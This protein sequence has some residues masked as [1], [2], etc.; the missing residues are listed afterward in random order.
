MQFSQP[1]QLCLL[2][3]ERGNRI[4]QYFA[5]NKD[6]FNKF[7]LECIETLRELSGF[8]PETPSA[9]TYRLPFQPSRVD[10]RRGASLRMSD[11][12]TSIFAW[13]HRGY[14]ELPKPSLSPYRHS[15]H[16]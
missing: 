8:E 13:P 16:T 7:A 1:M 14:S 5:L 4:F 11:D 3:R 12:H 2:L 10:G 9:L 6:K 15:R